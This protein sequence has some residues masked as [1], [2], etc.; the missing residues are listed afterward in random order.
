MRT[1]G[2]PARRHFRLS[3]QTVEGIGS[4]SS[5]LPPPPEVNIPSVQQGPGTPPVPVKSTSCLHGFGKELTGTSS[6]NGYQERLK[7]TLRKS[8]RI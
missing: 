8:S 3:K 4:T 6:L 5:K 1:L 7:A 2:A